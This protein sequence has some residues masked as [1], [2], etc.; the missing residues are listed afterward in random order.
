MGDLL[1][2]IGLGLVVIGIVYKFG[3]LG[4]FGHLPGD[5]SY[6]GEHTSFFFPLTSMILISII[7]SLLIRLFG[8]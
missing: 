3:F 2:V 5:F 4:W 8:R 7:V 6:Q 1:I